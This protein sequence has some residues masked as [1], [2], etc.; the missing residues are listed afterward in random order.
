MTMSLTMEQLKETDIELFRELEGKVVEFSESNNSRDD[1]LG[2]VGRVGLDNVEMLDVVYANSWGSHHFEGTT[3][4]HRNG[5]SK[6][7]ESDLSQEEYYEEYVKK[8]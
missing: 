2:L 5:I 3:V 8:D 6:I 4:Y 1:C 7:K